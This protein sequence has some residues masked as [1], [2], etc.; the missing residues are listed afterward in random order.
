[1][2]LLHEYYCVLCGSSTKYFLRFLVSRFRKGEQEI[3][4]FFYKL[5]KI[6]YA[7]QYRNMPRCKGNSEREISSSILHNK[8]MNL[9]LA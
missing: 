4:Y 1:M 7:N 8:G 3:L 6:F 5:L 9:L 2:K